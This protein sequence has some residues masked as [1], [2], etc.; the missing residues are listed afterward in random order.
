MANNTMKVDYLSPATITILGVPV[1]LVLLVGPS[2]PLLLGLDVMFKL[3][4]EFHPALRKFAISSSTVLGSE[5]SP[6]YQINFPEMLENKG[7]T[8]KDL[9][10]IEELPKE[11]DQVYSDAQLAQLQEKGNAQM[12]NLAFDFGTSYGTKVVDFKRRHM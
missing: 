12:M 10:P 11:P 4:M 5:P 6:F 7:I 3:D 2:R 1:P 9:V 8:E